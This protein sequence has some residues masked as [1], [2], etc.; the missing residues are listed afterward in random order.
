MTERNQIGG[1]F[2]GLDA[3]DACDLQHVSVGKVAG[4]NSI[5]RRPLHQHSAYGAGFPSCLGFVGHCD[6]VG[7][8]VLVE[9]TE[10][11]IDVVFG[12][13]GHVGAC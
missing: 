2:D 13:C 11:G 9:M 6:H 5:E 7:T 8:T 3:R 4:H 12:I 10:L 1:T